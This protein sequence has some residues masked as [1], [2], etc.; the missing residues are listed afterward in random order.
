MKSFVVS[1]LLLLL[2]CPWL[3]TAANKEEEKATA[4]LK[5]SH[6][7]HGRI[8]VPMLYARQ[9][10]SGTSNPATVPPST[11]QSPTP[12]SSPTP[13]QQSPSPDPPITTSDAPAPSRTVSPPP[14]TNAPPSETVVITRTGDNGAPT[15]IVTVTNRPSGQGNVNTRNPK[16]TT[17]GVPAPD[18]EAGDTTKKSSSTSVIIGLS[19]GGAAIVI[20]GVGI[21]VFR[22]LG[23][24]PS[25]R[26]RGR[27]ADLDAPGVSPTP[28]QPSSPS[29]SPVPGPQD[30]D[31]RFLHDTIHVSQSPSVTPFGAPVSAQP[32]EAYVPYEY[33]YAP[34]YATAA[35]H[36]TAGYD[37]YAPGHGPYAAYQGYDTSSQPRY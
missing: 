19:V 28:T 1:I 11:Q 8:G 6:E 5:L 10:P 3:C 37:A 25:K 36:S 2:S 35:A 12:S 13:S 27:L 24:K 26:F 16:A 4:L 14:I 34:P 23:L 29:T 31:K 17:S 22:K 30:R 32:Q 15:V 9:A 33:A 20:A 21:F 18:S 7:I